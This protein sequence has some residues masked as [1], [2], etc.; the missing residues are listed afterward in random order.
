MNTPALLLFHG[1]D[2][3]GNDC[4]GDALPVR[5]VGW[6]LRWAVV[7]AVLAVSAMVLTAFAYQLAAEQALARAAQAGLREAALPRATNA[8][9]EAAVRRRLADSS[10]FERATQ[11]RLAKVGDRTSVSLSVPS[12]AVLPRW[13]PVG[14]WNDGAHIAVRREQPVVTLLGAR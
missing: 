12:A 4:A 10:A 6:V 9:V 1:D 13:L 8:S 3:A 7:T 14:L 5:G 11:V 2:C